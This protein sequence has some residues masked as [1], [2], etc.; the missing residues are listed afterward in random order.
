MYQWILPFGCSTDSSTI[1]GSA[2]D[3]FYHLLITNRAIIKPH[4]LLEKMAHPKAM[5]I[6]AMLVLLVVAVVVLPMIV[7]YIGR[8]EPHFVISGFQDLAQAHNESIRV[9]PQAS[10][11]M[12]SMT[13]PELTTMCG[14]PNG[15]GQ[16]CPEGTFCD[17]ASQS[18]IPIFVGGDVP[19]TGYYS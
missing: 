10:Q 4:H 7:R 14:S 19:D 5:G 1:F 6:G 3:T 13:H 8:M 16:S 9:P 2:Y 11:S 15:N 18:C 12:V 17:G